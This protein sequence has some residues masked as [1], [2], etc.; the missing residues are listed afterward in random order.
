MTTKSLG[1]KILHF[2]LVKII[3]GFFVVVFAYG[4]SQFLI[5]AIFKSSSL[6]GDIKD[7]TEGLFSSAV[8]IAAYCLLFRFYEKRRI[9]EFSIKSLGKNLL[10][11]LLLGIVLQSLTVL[12]IYLKGGYEIV[13]VNSFIYVIP[14]LTMAFT[15]SIIEEILLRGI[16]FRIIE[17]KLGSYLALLISAIFFGL[18]HAGNPNSSLIL[19]LGLAIQAGLL[20]GVSYIYTR[21]LWLPIALH[22]AWNFMQAGIYGAVVSGV[23]VEKSLITSKITGAEWYTGGEFG[24]EGSIQATVFCLIAMVILLYL[25]HR[26]NKLILPFWKKKRMRLF[27]FCI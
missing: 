21:N 3:I 13:S 1:Y 10:I 17:E 6:S 27:D 9:T 16:M 7:M 18:M 23:T 15:S 11:G 26:D 19:S 12:V 4:G 14:A 24:P 20:L 22:F 8:A 2:P 5:D 25:C